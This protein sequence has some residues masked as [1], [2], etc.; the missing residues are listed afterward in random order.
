MNKQPTVSQIK[1]ILAD[2]ANHERAQQSQKFFKT[3][4]GQYAAHDKF[5]G[6]TV[7]QLRAFAKTFNGLPLPEIQILL[8]SAI[9]E[10]RLLALFL[11]VNAYKKGKDD[12][13]ERIYQCYLAHLDHINNWDLVD[14]SAHLIIGPHLKTDDLL[15]ELSNSTN[16][17]RRRI[18]IVA[19]WHYIKQHHFI[20]TLTIAKRLLQDDHD[21]IHKATGWMLREMGKKDAQVL[22]QFLLE[23]AAIM[24]RTMLR[25]AIEKFSAE[26]RAHYLR[27]KYTVT[28]TK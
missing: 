5:I 15:I 16:I 20:P 13:K 14:S 10:E 19:T 25:Y 3:G 22:E 28:P 2:C 7:P 24:P 1:L 21:L 27:A 12:Q 9:H 8:T 23:N 18:A 26:T 6:I 11:L 17:W 4:E